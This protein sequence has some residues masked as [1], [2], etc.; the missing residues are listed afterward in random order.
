MN[1]SKSETYNYQ[2]EKPYLF[3][4]K[5]QIDF[6]NV[7]DAANKMLQKSGCFM[8]YS[9]QN[10]L[11]LFKTQACL[12][13]LVEMGEL[14]EVTINSCLWQHRIYIKGNDQ[15][16][17][18]RPLQAPARFYLQDCLRELKFGRPAQDQLF[19]Q[20]WIDELNKD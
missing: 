19:L 14:I 3:T 16:K 8:A 20:K 5:G 11:D 18:L 2:N 12:D 17:E 9:V 7:R 10:D 4:E 15:Q 6:L 13:M 1:N